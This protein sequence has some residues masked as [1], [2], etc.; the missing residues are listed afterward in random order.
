MLHGDKVW[1]G[2]T[3]G[4]STNCAEGF[5]LSGNGT[6][7]TWRVDTAAVLTVSV[8]PNGAIGPL[9]INGV[10]API[11][12]SSNSAQQFTPGCKPLLIPEKTHLYFGASGN[13]RFNDNF[14]GRVL[15]FNFD[16]LLV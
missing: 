1:V 15:S 9:L 8:L 5:L 13:A 11:A 3:N 12:P 2:N 6:A 4:E 14:V 16:P 7:P 10:P